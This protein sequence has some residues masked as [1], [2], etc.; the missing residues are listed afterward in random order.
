MLFFKDADLNTITTLRSTHEG[1]RGSSDDI[2]IHIR[3]DNASKYY[4]DVRLV[5]ENLS[6][7]LE[8][9]GW[10]DTGWG[11]KLSYG[12]RQPTEREWTAIA[13]GLELQLPNI[14]S[15]SAGD[16][17]TDF[18]CWVRISCPGNQSAQLK[19]NLQLKLLFLERNVVP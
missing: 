8:D 7:I 3:N 13:P 17:S 19:Q 9:E 5:A 11:V 1:Y 6:E 2:L 18:P 12:S 4:E 14:G 16:T 15:I 10:G